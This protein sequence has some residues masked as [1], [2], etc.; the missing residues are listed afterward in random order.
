MQ[1]N[2][3]N[4]SLALYWSSSIFGN[5]PTR[6]GVT[7]RV[8][9]P[10]GSN[11]SLETIVDSTYLEYFDNKV[12]II[13]EKA[14]EALSKKIGTN[15]ILLVTESYSHCE[16]KPIADALSTKY[17]GVPSAVAYNPFYSCFTGYIESVIDGNMVLVKQCHGIFTYA[18]V[19]S[20]LIAMLQPSNGHVNG[21]L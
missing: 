7:I 21:H 11:K 6:V 2:P 19:P 4:R 8:Q 3:I 1:T 14:K 13:F 15:K 20:H 12:S 9:K 5:Q 16:S 17:S 18:L 10:D